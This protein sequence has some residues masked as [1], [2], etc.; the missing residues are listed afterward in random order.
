MGHLRRALPKA[1]PLLIQYAPMDADDMDKARRVIELALESGGSRI[2][3]FT[4]KSIR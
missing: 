4:E 1:S 3:I 2:S